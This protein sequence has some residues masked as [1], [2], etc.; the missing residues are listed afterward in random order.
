LKVVI[1]DSIAAFGADPAMRGEQGE[2]S[3]HR[4]TIQAVRTNGCDAGVASDSTLLRSG[5]GLRVILEFP[6]DPVWWVVGSAF[7]PGRHLELQ[8]ALVGLRDP[9]LF[10]GI[11]KRIT[12]YL[13]A[14]ETELQA[15]REA[16]PLAA[17]YFGEANE[18][19]K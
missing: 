3:S 12:H 16:M 17:K 6:S 2:L 10:H 9:A 13:P 14:D 5:P 4:L 19:E 15:L 7:P 1:L 8:S 11:S 18:K